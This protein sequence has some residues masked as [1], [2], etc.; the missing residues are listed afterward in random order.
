MIDD[1]QMLAQ[2]LRSRQPLQQ[3][4]NPYAAGSASPYTPSANI[5]PVSGVGYIKDPRYEVAS[6]D[7]AIEEKALENQRLMAQR[8][9]ESGQEAP[10]MIKAGNIN[11]AGAS[12][13]SAFNQGLRGWL[14][15]R[16]QQ[17]VDERDEILAGKKAES[18][19]AIGSIEQQI[20]QENR[21]KEAAKSQLSLDKFEEKKRHAKFLEDQATGS[22]ALAKTKEARAVAEELRKVAAAAKAE[23]KP[24]TVTTREMIND[25]G[26]TIEAWTTG[27]GIWTSGEDG[28]PVRVDQS[29]WRRAPTATVTDVDAGT[30]LDLENIDNRRRVI[31]DSLGSAGERDRANLLISTGEQLQRLVSEGN[32]Q[33]KNGDTPARIKSFAGDF[34]RLVA[35]DALEDAAS[36]WANEMAYTD[37]QIA[38]IG[39]LENAIGD[40]RKARTGAN[41]T[42]IET[43]LGK[44]WDPTVK[45]I[46]FEERTARASRL[47]RYVNTKLKATSGIEGF[48]VIPPFDPNLHAKDAIIA[49]EPIRI[50]DPQPQEAS[51]GNLTSKQPSMEELEAEEKALLERFPG[52]MEESL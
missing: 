37:E 24:D 38:F 5:M 26:D 34:A 51:M 41:V 45:G 22:S 27:A 44:N 42:K 50:G 31:V 19:A 29:K 28:T 3:P 36:N 48:D 17:K 21:D 32:R 8:L 18:A 13:L 2:I 20:A 16:N 6:R 14:G 35:P 46:N 9:A 33:I 12:P 25:E 23:L 30:G 10:E 47:Q 11:V 39:D 40:L 15:M 43:E 1:P 7:Y 49:R 4:I 52:V